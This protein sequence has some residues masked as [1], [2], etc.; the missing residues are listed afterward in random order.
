MMQFPQYSMQQYL[1]IR[2]AYAPSYS[3]SGNR[4]AFLTD[5]TGTPQ[6]WMVNADRKAQDVLWPD[7]LTFSDERVEA[8]SFSPVDENLLLFVRDR[9]GNENGQL[10]LLSL[11]TGQERPLSEGMDEVMHVPGSWAP[12]GRS[13]L[14][15]ANRRHPGLFDVYLQPLDGEARLVWENPQPGFIFNMEFSPD[16]SH[17]LVMRMVSSFHHD[18]F[19]IDLETKTARQLSDPVRDVVFD[20]ADYSLDGSL[21]LTTDQD[22][23]FIYLGRMDRE[24]GIITPLIQEEADIELARLSP[25]REHLAY[26]VNRG[27][28]SE[29]HVLDLE[30][31]LKHSMPP[32]GR[33]P[34]LL[35]GVRGEDCMRFSPGSDALAIAYTGA[36]TPTNIWQWDWQAGTMQPLTRS[37]AAGIHP[38]SLIAP[39]LVQFPTF[40]IDS[41]SGQTRRIPAWLYLPRDTEGPLPVVIQVHG[42]PEG[43]YRPNLNAVAQYLVQQGFAVLATNVRG[44]TGYGK[45]YSHLDDV[46]KRMDSVNDL[47]HAALWLKSQPRFAPDKIAVM[48]ASYGGFMVLS[49]LTTYPD[50][51]AAGVDIVGISNFVTFLENTSEYRRAHRSAEYGSLEKNREFLESISPSNHLDRIQAPLFVIHGSNDPRVP[52]TETRQIVDK[53]KMRGIPVQSMFFD[54]EGHGLVKLKNKLAAYPEVAVFLKKHLKGGVG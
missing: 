49:A 18:L 36:C 10:F 2:S 23:D 29:I 47:A 43:Q 20:W 42:G 3:A 28:I 11:D 38:D 17:A 9:G 51:W 6:V 15:A 8:V 14:F 46:E 44:S 21:L 48:G 27:G 22:S 25:D 26:A 40:D 33:G 13:F 54:D 12:C 50:L 1:N 19:E 35:F 16:G 7:Q 34:G 4:L 37:A 41:A 39:E 32:V 53:I 30:T 5:I 24:T 31:G 45:T 52:V